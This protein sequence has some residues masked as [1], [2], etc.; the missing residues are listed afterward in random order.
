MQCK[1][2]AIILLIFLTGA[3][4]EKRQGKFL[5]LGKSSILVE[6]GSVVGTQVD[7]VIR[8]VRC[9]D[10]KYG[11]DDD[12][13]RV[14]NGAKDE[15]VY[16]MEGRLT[17]ILKD[18]AGIREIGLTPT[19]AKLKNGLY[20]ASDGNGNYP[21]EI[22]VL[23][24]EYRTAMFSPDKKTAILP[25]THGFH[26]IAGQAI[27]IN[28]YVKLGL[29][30]ACMDQPAKS[31]AALF[32]AKNGI[33]CYAPCDRY[34]ALLVGYK[35]ENKKAAMIIGTAPIRARG[36]SAVI[37][38]QP[39]KISLE[40][41]IVVQD[42]LLGYPDQY[43]DTPAR[44]FRALNKKMKLDLQMVEVLANVGETEKLT[45]K[46][47]EIGAKVI[48]VRVHNCEDATGVS[49]WLGEDSSHRAILFHSAIYE[50]GYEMFFEFPK[51]TSFGDLCP[52]VE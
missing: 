8:D 9:S 33:N 46:A 1:V 14:P 17:K 30:M 38:D 2:S 6:Q 44:Y 26:M 23:R 19:Y 50:P 41:K 13:F 45:N 35:T 32:L 49:K 51:Q 24:T 25:D 12:P 22:N 47:R 42:S 21:F 48:A 34:A 15:F 18:C 52:V 39:V 4:A 5:I 29:V 43:C 37:G 20:W 27:R 11:E 36:N 28:H 3:H 40:E 10:S 7:R 16:Y 31:E